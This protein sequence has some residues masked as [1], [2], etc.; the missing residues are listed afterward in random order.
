MAK[1][2]KHKLATPFGRLLAGAIALGAILPM[3]AAAQ[4]AGT[5]NGEA[6]M[7]QKPYTFLLIDQLEHGWSRGAN[8]VYW[9]AQGWYGGDYN[10]LWLKTEGD[11]LATRAEGKAELQALYSRSVAPYWDLQA[12]IRHERRF[13]RGPNSSRTFA[14]LGIQ[15]LAPYWFDLEPTLF[16]SEDG[17]LSARLTAEY[18]LLLTQR[19]IAQPRLE[20]NASARKVDEFDIGSGIND[21]DLGLRLRYE[22]R[23]EFAPYVGISWNRK[24]GQTA[25]MARQGGYDVDNTAIVAGL[26]VWY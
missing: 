18:D 12:G 25:D 1:T 22:I 11:T 3:A 17:D 20:V 9:D 4:D 19:L 5:G 16:I 24:F 6:V 13:G 26:R 21:M 10:K 15:G 23:R 8:T 14:V 2:A 7:D